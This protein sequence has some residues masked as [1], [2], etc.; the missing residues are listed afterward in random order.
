[1]RP[2]NFVAIFS[3]VKVYLR[4]NPLGD[5]GQVRSTQ[6]DSHLVAALDFMTGLRLLGADLPSKIYNAT[7]TANSKKWARFLC[8]VSMLFGIRGLYG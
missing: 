4:Q 3:Q 7:A 8:Y 2:E 6:I 1:M 5:Q